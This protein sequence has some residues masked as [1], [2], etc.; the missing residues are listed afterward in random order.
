MFKQQKIITVS[1]VAA[2]PIVSIL[3][4]KQS[5]QGGVFKT[6]KTDHFLV[7]LAVRVLFPKFLGRLRVAY[8]RTAWNYKGAHVVLCKMD[9]NLVRY[10]CQ[11]GGVLKLYL[12]KKDPFL[13]FLAIWV[14]F[15]KFLGRLRIDFSYNS[16]KW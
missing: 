7:F 6:M 5:W 4:H 12:L 8:I 13:V 9:F 3:F 11:Q 2:C 15:P 16:M 14:F 10:R 1:H